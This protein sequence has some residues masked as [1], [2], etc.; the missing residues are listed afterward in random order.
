MILVVSFL[1]INTAL[2]DNTSK[3]VGG[4][5][6]H[7]SILDGFVVFCMANCL[8]GLFAVLELL[9]SRE[10]YNPTFLHDEYFNGYGS[11]KLFIIQ[12]N[13]VARSAKSRFG[14]KPWG[15]L[16]RCSRM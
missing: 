10:V 13:E 11:N 7:F 5:K 15:V 8:F 1:C 2:N 16:D 6:N 14:N 12:G 3:V 9:S 4:D